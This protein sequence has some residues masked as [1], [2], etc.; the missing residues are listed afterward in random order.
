MGLFA[1]AVVLPL[2][3]L[4]LGCTS[5]AGSVEHERHTVSALRPELFKPGALTLPNTRTSVKFAVIGDSGR[6]STPQRELAAQLTRFR[7]T[8]PFAFVLMLGDNIYEGPA[9]PEDYRRKFEEPYGPLLQAGVEFFAVLGNHDDPKEIHYPSFNMK[10]ER[11]YSFT[12]PE[13]LL[14]RIATR[15]EFFALDTTYPDPGQLQWLEERL[16]TSTATWKISFF[17]HPLYTTGRYATASRAYRWV[18]EPMLVRHGVDV[19][20]SGHEHLYQRSNLQ[21]GIQYFVSGGA[22]SVRVE[23]GSTSPLIAKSYAQDLHFMLV[24]IDRD[25]LHFQAISRTGATIDA[26]TLSKDRSA[27]GS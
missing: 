24:E 7:D 18:L 3:A 25:T 13:D 22:G 27:T 23:D 14:A 9:S 12:P 8:F 16:E 2:F 4:A 17:H 10:G 19:A 15:V 6:W 5:G 26:G 21:Q 11:Y 20:F 1:R